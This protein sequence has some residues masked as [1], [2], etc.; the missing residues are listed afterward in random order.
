MSDRVQ[1]IERGIDVLIAL[2]DGPKTLAQVTRQTG[3][4][5]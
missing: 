4:S 3:L 1:S 2:V 5:K